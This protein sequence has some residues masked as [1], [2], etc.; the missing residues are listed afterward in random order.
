M[1]P[2]TLPC[3]SP[4]PPFKASKCSHVFTLISFMSTVSCDHLRGCETSPLCH[5]PARPPVCH[6]QLRAPSAS[7]G[8]SPCSL[9]GGISGG[10]EE[11]RSSVPVISQCPPP[12]RWTTSGK[13]QHLGQQGGLAIMAAAA[14]A[15][16]AFC[17]EICSQISLSDPLMTF[18]SLSSQAHVQPERNR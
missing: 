14:A 16:A 9:G 18:V 10:K 1:S 12:S 7:A 11:S 5:R 2:S 3:E 6:R 4:P 17:T 13:S 8:A 15:A